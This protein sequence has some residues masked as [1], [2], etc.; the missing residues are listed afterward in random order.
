M[1]LSENRSKVEASLELKF[2]DKNMARS[3]LKAIS[4]DNVQVPEGIEIKTDLRDNVLVL[5]IGCSRGIGS[6]IATL[7][8]LLSCVQAA[9]RAI[10]QL[11]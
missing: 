1:N 11:E 8:D 6:M 7:D 5:K 10:K 4:P 3:I 2:Q 9:E